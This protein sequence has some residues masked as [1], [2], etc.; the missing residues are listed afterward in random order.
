M[1]AKVNTLNEQQVAQL[2][3]AKIAKE[4]PGLAKLLQQSQPTQTTAP[5]EVSANA[6]SWVDS[7]DKG[8]MDLET[9]LTKIGSSKEAAPLKNEVMQYVASR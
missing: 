9:I 8:T 2:Q 4:S 6:K 3:M 7:W 5:K 1:N